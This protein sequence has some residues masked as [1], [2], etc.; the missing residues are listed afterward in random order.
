MSRPVTKLPS[1]VPAIT[2]RPEKPKYE[3]EPEE[4]PP[5]E[6]DPARREEEEHQREERAEQQRQELLAREQQATLRLSKAQTALSKTLSAG[7]IEPDS[8]SRFVTE[9]DHSD[10]DRILSDNM[11]TVI[12]RYVIS[13]HM[14]YIK[15]ISPLGDVLFIHVDQ[16]GVS[17]VDIGDFTTVRSVEG[18]KISVSDKTAA[19]TCTSQ[20]TCGVALQCEDE[21]CVIVRTDDGH[22]EQNSFML[23]EGYSE[24]TI[25][26]VGSSIAFPVVKLSEIKLDPRGTAERIA[27]ASMKIYDNSYS[28]STSE[29]G[30][31]M[32]QIEKLHDH[33]RRFTEVRDTHIRKHTLDI[34]KLSTM[35]KKHFQEYL[36][37]TMSADNH[38]RYTSV[39]VNIYARTRELTKIISVSNTVA[40]LE[41]EIITTRSRISAL[42]EVLEHSMGFFEDRGG[43]RILTTEE[44]LKI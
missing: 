4:S 41:Q 27:S 43:S 16:K 15:A 21:L 7:A 32:S 42:L 25:T 22:N 14:T 28:I 34:Y 12:S 40:Q 38:K 10:I 36:K 9:S 24:K 29:L 2:R 18:K 37:G 1:R 30:S 5:P 6:V 20:S 44:A 23:T 39:L 19:A 33:S 35:A 31:L 8:V 11:Y 3:E 13:E 17:T 26:P